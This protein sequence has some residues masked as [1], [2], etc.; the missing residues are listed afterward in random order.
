MVAQQ[1]IDQAAAE[2]FAGKVLGDL[3]G[4]TNT[5][6]ARVGDRLGLFKSLASKGPAT[7]AELAER[8]GTN[9]RYVREWLAALASAEYL[10]YDPTSA[11]FTL[12]AEHALALAQEGGPMFLGGIP[13]QFMGLLTTLDKVEDAFRNG[14]G[15]ANDEFAV[16]TWDGMSRLT[17]TWTDNNLV[18]NW[19]PQMPDVQARLERGALL[20]DVGSGYGQAIIKLAQAFPNS[21]FVGY[22][23]NARSIAR[24]RAEAERAGVS[25]RV[26]FE[27]RDASTG[28]PEQ[29]DLITTFDVVHDTVDP[30]KLLTAIRQALKQDGIYICQEINGS[31]RLEENIGT[32]GALLYGVSVLFCMTQSL[33]AHGEGLGTFGLPEPKVRELSAEAGFGAVRRVPIEDPFNSFY[34]IRASVGGI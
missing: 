1:T 19:L 10:T 14:G 32:V 13:Q 28:L 6:L 16:D 22:D 7:S 2:A 12:P 34:E 24:A 33:A 31:E 4:V 11:R 17:A 21:R 26:R 20:A 8:T 25:D 27:Q 15:V 5:A 29:Y 30:L 9:E 3:A 18:Q 23:I